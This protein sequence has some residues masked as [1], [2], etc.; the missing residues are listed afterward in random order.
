MHRHRRRP[1]QF[2][3]LDI[4]L[5][6]HT[7]VWCISFDDDDDVVHFYCVSKI[8]HQMLEIAQIPAQPQQQHREQQQQRQ[9]D[10]DSLTHRMDWTCSP[11]SDDD[12]CARRFSMYFS[13]FECNCACTSDIHRFRSAVV[14]SVCAPHACIHTCKRRCDL[15]R[16]RI[17]VIDDDDDDGSVDRMKEKDKNRIFIVQ[18]C[19]WFFRLVCRRCCCCLQCCC[20]CCFWYFWCCCCCCL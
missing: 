12:V 3:L 1:I 6:N 15:F 13:P 2:Q 14:C 18:H 11:N 16:N 4:Y 5:F 17:V 10:T 20:C 19:W 9:S 7:F 8:M